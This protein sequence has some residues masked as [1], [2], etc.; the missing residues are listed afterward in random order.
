M[1]RFIDREG[2]FLALVLGIAGIAVCSGLLYPAIPD[3]VVDGRAGPVRGHGVRGRRRRRIYLLVARSSPIGRS[4]TAQGIFGASGTV[5]TIVASLGA[6]YLA[7]TS[8]SGSRS[9]DRRSVTLIA[10]VIG[11]L[12]G[13]RRL[14]DAM[15]PHAPAQAAAAARRRRAAALFDGSGDR[16]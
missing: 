15:Q 1:G 11:L 4:S 16:R 10:L 3:D 5:G 2:G 14:Y 9:S 8:T 12:I 6:G 13:R 7:A